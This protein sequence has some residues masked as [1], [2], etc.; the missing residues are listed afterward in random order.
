VA[1]ACPQRLAF[2]VHLQPDGTVQEV[3]LVEPQPLSASCRPAAESARR[4]I[5][6]ASPLQGT[7]GVDAIVVRFDYNSLL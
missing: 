6:K 3:E 7:K 4:A 5:L 1:E 2:R